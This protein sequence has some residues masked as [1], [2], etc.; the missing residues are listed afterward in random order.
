MLMACVWN[1]YEAIRGPFLPDREDERL[2]RVVEKLPGMLT[3]GMPNPASKDEDLNRMSPVQRSRVSA[4]AR[5][6]RDRLKEIVEACDEKRRAIDLMHA[7]FGKRVPDRPDL[8]SIPVRAEATI[9]SQPKRV[10]PAPV[11]GRSQSG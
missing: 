9:T 11:V 10:V 4:E 2:L 3:K 5:K 7:A 8:V 6:L 1:A